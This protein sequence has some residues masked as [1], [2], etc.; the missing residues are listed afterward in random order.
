MTTMNP[1]QSREF[2]KAV[3]E[4]A[5]VS[6]EHV[7]ADSLAVSIEGAATEATVTWRGVATIPRETLS[8]ILERVTG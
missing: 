3:L 7:E 8:E 1:D 6:P 5:G 2:S 4:A